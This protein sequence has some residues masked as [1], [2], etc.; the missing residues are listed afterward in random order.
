MGLD[1]S[2]MCISIKPA[3]PVDFKPVEE[4]YEVQYW[5]KHPNLHGWMEALYYKK[6]GKAESF[7]CVPVELTL[8]DIDAL[9]DAIQ[10]GSLPETQGFF[11]GKTTGDEEIKDLEFCHRA[12]KL[13]ER[14]EYLY[15]D[16]WW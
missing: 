12:R 9:E 7:N 2:V 4:P 1:Q 10:S 15:Y 6:G 11:F 14:G 8:E 16:S 13:L 3:A 5:R